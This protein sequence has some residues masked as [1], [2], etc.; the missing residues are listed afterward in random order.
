MAYNPGGGQNPGND[1]MFNDGP[2]PKDGMEEGGDKGE[3]TGILPKEILAGKDFKP[4]EE[5]VLKIVAIHDNDVEVAYAS[6]EGKGE[7]EGSE[8]HEEAPM[9]EGAPSNDS[10]SMM[11]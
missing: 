7:K 5:I 11:Y 4:G 3:V 2:A 8:P 6:E 9:S 10:A 1:D